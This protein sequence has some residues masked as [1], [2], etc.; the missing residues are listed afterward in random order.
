MNSIGAH[1]N[2]QRG[3]YILWKNIASASGTQGSNK[4]TEDRLMWISVSLDI[5]QIDQLICYFQHSIYVLYVI[6]IPDAWVCCDL[7]TANYINLV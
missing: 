2:M 4:S 7:Y 6:L 5:S 1:T 3:S